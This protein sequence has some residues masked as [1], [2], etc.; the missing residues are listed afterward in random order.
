M[1]EVASAEDW[2]SFLSPFKKKKNAFLLYKGSIQIV[3]KGAKQKPGVALLQSGCHQYTVRASRSHSVLTHWRAELPQHKRHRPC[4]EPGFS[5]KTRGSLDW[6]FR[7]EPM[8]VGGWGV[9]GE[10]GLPGPLQGSA[11]PDWVQGLDLEDP[12][13]HHKGLGF[14]SAGSRSC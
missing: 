11:Q 9:E 10:R 13:C 5:E 1:E 2:W 12:L 4:G 3:L 7:R 8:A 6:I 14:Y